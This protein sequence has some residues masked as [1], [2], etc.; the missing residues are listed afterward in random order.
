MTF[1]EQ[2]EKQYKEGYDKVHG[3]GRITILEH[4]WKETSRVEATVINEG[5]IVYTCEECGKTK[6]EV[7][8]KPEY[9]GF[10]LT[11]GTPFAFLNAEEDLFSR[12]S[13]PV[14]VIILILGA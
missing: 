6:E 3:Q 11:D 2:L 14:I 1:L 13:S 9:T 5:K 7:I 4:E 12:N 10:T 8:P